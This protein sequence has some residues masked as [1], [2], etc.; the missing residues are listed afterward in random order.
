MQITIELNDQKLS[1]IKSLMVDGNITDKEVLNVALT[2]LMKL[3][4]EKR[5]G[6]LIGYYDA[7]RDVFTEVKIASTKNFV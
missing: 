2:L 6:K 5:N 4:T 1:E 7:N 3:C